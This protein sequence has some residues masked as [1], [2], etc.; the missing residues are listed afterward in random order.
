MGLELSEG[1]DWVTSEATLNRTL[2]D[3]FYFT[4]KEHLKSHHT[5]NCGTGLPLYP[6]WQHQKCSQFLSLTQF[7]YFFFN[8]K[9][10]FSFKGWKAPAYIVN[11]TKFSLFLSYKEF[12]AISKSHHVFTHQTLPQPAG[13]RNYFSHWTIVT[14]QFSDRFCAMTCLLSLTFY[15][16]KT[17]WNC[18]LGFIVLG[19]FPVTKFSSPC[20]SLTQASRVSLHYLGP[21]KRSS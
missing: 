21:Q 12:L 10:L 14:P 5:F 6:T 16:P 2:D 11:K 13:R 17:C 3:P 7:T 9:M 19:P 4:S 15:I 20:P 8:Q 18:L 1:R